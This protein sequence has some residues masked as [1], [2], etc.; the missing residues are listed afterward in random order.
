VLDLVT[1]TGDKPTPA[2]RAAV[3]RPWK[4]EIFATAYIPDS[5]Q[6]RDP[7][8]S[9]AWGA[10]GDGLV[11]IAPALVVTAGLDRLRDEAVCYAG[12]LDAVG[13]LS[14]YLEVDDADH[15]Y[16]TIGDAPDSA[17]VTRRMY[18]LIADL[19]AR[20]TESGRR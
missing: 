19:V 18:A 9:P 7:L 12:R 16:N 13:A 1:K 6:R 10:N 17:D 5:T 3:L 4:C 15:G 20:A 11:G 14:D 8:A 2:G